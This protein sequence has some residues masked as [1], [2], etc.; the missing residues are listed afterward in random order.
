MCSAQW[1]RVYKVDFVQS[2]SYSRLHTITVQISASL[3]VTHINTHVAIITIRAGPTYVEVHNYSSTITYILSQ[4]I[5]TIQLQ[6]SL[7]FSLLGLQQYSYSV[8]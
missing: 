3:G 4:L 1:L 6:Y 7:L 5:A 2:T 8:S